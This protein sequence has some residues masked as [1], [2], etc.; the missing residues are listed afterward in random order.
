M[1]VNAGAIASK[2]NSYTNSSIGKERMRSTIQNIRKSGG[3]GARTEAGS[4]VVTYAAIHAAAKDLISIIKKH[5]A[6]A[7]IPASVMSDVESFQ[8]AGF[9]ENGDGSVNVSLSMSADLSRSSLEPSTYGGAY[10]IVALFNAG[11]SAKGTVYGHWESA[12]VDVL[13]LP[14]REGLYFLQAAIDEF[15]AKYGDAYNVTVS[16]DGQYE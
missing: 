2:L 8:E 13:S 12:G 1:G 4:V 6:S 9:S 10:N 3:I 11:Y 16:L 7:G 14:Q 5:A 15:S